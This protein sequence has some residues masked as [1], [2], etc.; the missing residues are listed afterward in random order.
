MWTTRGLLQQVVLV[1]VQAL[2]AR[3]ANNMLVR[4]PL[5]SAFGIIAPPALR[6]ARLCT[7]PSVGRNA[8]RALPTIEQIRQGGPNDLESARLDLSHAISLMPP[9]TESLES[10]RGELLRLLG[11]T[12]L[13]LG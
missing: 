9:F 10:R 3:L 2:R 13:R 7:A 6:M 11:A 12:H 8:G 5:Q 1:T 4:R